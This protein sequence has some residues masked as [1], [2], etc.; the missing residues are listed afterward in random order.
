MVTQTLDH[1]S[2]RV[3]CDLEFYSH[4]D[5]KSRLPVDLGKGRTQV[6]L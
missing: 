5:G 1:A 6:D 4:L 3:V 2:K